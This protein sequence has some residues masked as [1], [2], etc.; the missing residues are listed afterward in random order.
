[1]ACTKQC[2][3]GECKNIHSPVEARRIPVPDPWAIKPDRQMVYT[4]MWSYTDNSDY[5]VVDVAFRRK[6]DAEELI[7]LL[8][9]HSQSKR[10]VLCQSVLKS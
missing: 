5:G 9:E 10:F 8:D 4:I 1:M 7:K 6:E 2:W 3:A